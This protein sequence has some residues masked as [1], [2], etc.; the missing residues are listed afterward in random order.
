[1]ASVEKLKQLAEGGF[2][3]RANYIEYKVDNALSV[4]TKHS[5]APFSVLV[6][7]IGP[8]FVPRLGI[9][10]NIF[11]CFPQLHSNQSERGTCVPVPVEFDVDIKQKAVAGNPNRVKTIIRKGVVGALVIHPNDPSEVRK[12]EDPTLYDYMKQSFTE[13]VKYCNRS[14]ANIGMNRI[15]TEDKWPNHES[16]IEQVCYEQDF[17]GKVFV[18]T[19]REK[20]KQAGG[21]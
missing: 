11:S 15:G 9:Q 13:L 6:A 10:K 4:F 21:Q 3:S 16:I 14:G 17:K 20:R 1:M 7:D 5:R 2:G 8:H 19:P 18:Y 12:P